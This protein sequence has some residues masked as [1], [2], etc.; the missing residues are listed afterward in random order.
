MEIDRL[1]R[2]E[3]DELQS[4]PQQKPEDDFLSDINPIYKYPSS[5]DA[6]QNRKDE[7]YLK[8][9]KIQEEFE[10]AEKYRK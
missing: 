1:L 4:K 5:S 10:R 7:Q 2:P 9:K 3:M 8:F 6:R